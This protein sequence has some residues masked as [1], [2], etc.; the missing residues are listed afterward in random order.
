MRA[1]F[2]MDI[3]AIGIIC[4]VGCT[5]INKANSLKNQPSGVYFSLV[6]K[7]K[8]S[9]FY[10]RLADNNW[11]FV[12]TSKP[13]DEAIESVFLSPSPDERL[14]LVEMPKGHDRK[15]HGELARMGNFAVIA[16]H[17]DEELH[18]IEGRPE[19]YGEALSSQEKQWP[20]SESA[21]VLNLNFQP[22]RS[23]P[24]LKHS[25]ID[26]AYLMTKV[27]QLS[28]E[29][30]VTINSRSLKITERKR[31]EN[32]ANA[33]AWLRQEYESIGF[34]ATEL[35]Y[36]GRS[37]G[38]SAN[39]IA[40]KR[41]LNP[42]RVLLVSSHLDSVGNAGADDN[43]AG[44]ISAL[45]MA[46]ALKNVA[47]PYTLRIIA[48]DEEELGLVG[49]EAYASM[50]VNNGEIDELVGVINMEMTGYNARGD[51]AFH[52]IDCNENSST[53][54][55]DV[56]KGIA[57]RDSTLNL[58]SVEACTSRSDHAS[59]WRAGKPAVVLSQN[60]FGGDGNPCYH[61]PCDRTNIMNFDYMKNMTTLLTK[62][63]AEMMNK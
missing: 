1:M 9:R 27:R 34:T 43:G 23:W 61:R 49:S 41:G 35:P 50:L 25:E 19:F 46:N 48:F 37:Y 22:D 11:H 59:F 14:V 40:E 60:F 15:L 3:A 4:A 12:A 17:F 56:F 51:G 5:G 31:D 10:N 42:H 28:G 58:H 32:K 53:E 57:N 18:M 47:L 7:S 54:L 24:A 62:A 38:N 20:G 8:V 39:L 52:I 63:V 26:K 16:D 45:A 30:P 36:E 2:K 6:R 55:S 33:R 29:Q 13:I 21:R 44:T